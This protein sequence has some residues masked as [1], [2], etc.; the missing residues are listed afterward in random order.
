MK[1]F[2]LLTLM[3]VLNLCLLAQESFT[4]YG[5][6]R[7]SETEEIIEYATIGIKGK[8]QGTISNEL[9][10]FSFIIDEPSEKDEIVF[11]A[12][13]YKARSF[14]L[15]ELMMDNEALEV[16][17]DPATYSLE[18][19][20]VTGVNPLDI[21]E[22]A[23][24]GIYK[25]YPTSPHLLKGFYR[26]YME[27]DG[28]YVRL[29]EAAVDIIEDGYKVKGKNVHSREKVLVKQIRNADEYRKFDAY[30]Y[31]G[32]SYMLNEN[33]AGYNPGGVLNTYPA[34]DWKFE[35]EEK[36]L[37]EGE[38]T[39]V[40]SF[41]PRSEKY[42]RPS[43]LV[44]LSTEDYSIVKMDWSINNALDSWLKKYYSDTVYIEHKNWEANFSYKR[45]KD[46]MYLNYIK[47]TRSYDVIDSD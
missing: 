32:L 20:V 45:F 2:T 24:E 37:V 5:F 8:A 1:Q 21:V 18:E 33:I 30:L 42:A 22:K 26:E 4:V 29:I 13:G 11:S 3:L 43:G 14:P 46:K 23:L 35:F 6:I 27:E 44:Y 34:S 7:N 15:A 38:E 39:Y 28:A 19:I 41:I 12:I 31:D 16:L 40:I 47:H 25:N 17:L 36:T 9:G 10:E